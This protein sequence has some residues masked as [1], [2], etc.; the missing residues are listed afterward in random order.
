MRWFLIL[1]ANI[2][3]SIFTM[4]LSPVIALFA[5][6]DQYPRWLHWATVHDYPAHGDDNLVPYPYVTTGWKGWWNRTWYAF[7]NPAYNFDRDQC[8]FIPTD[9][10]VVTYGSKTLEDGV[11][12]D[13]WLFAQCGYAWLLLIT[14]HWSATRSTKIVL[15]WKLWNAPSLCQF[16]FSPF[17]FYWPLK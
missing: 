5:R 2:I 6:D 3:V 16:V 12:A 11:L 4:L 14:H 17:G 9:K 10:P 15:G 8:G 13:G 7:R 1:P